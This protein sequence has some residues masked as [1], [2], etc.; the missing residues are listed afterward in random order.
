[1]KRKAN[2]SPLPTEAEEQRTVAA[3]LDW[4]QICWFHPANETGTAH[5][6]G[7]R[8]RMK[9]QGVKPGVPDIVIIDPPNESRNPYIRGAVIEM[10]RRKGGVL[11]DT[12]NAWINA[13]GSRHWLAAVCN[14]SDE[15]I[16]QLVSWGYGK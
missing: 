6:Y 12:Q 7:L 4:H 8:V 11:T 15:A 3:W 14:G 10:K 13:F 5:G 9:Q 2:T 16:A 1:M